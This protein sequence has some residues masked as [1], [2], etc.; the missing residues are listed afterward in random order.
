MNEDDLKAPYRKL[1]AVEDQIELN[2][3]LE[4]YTGYFKQK[5]KGMPIFPVD[6]IQ[7]KWAKD[8]KKLCGMKAAE[9]IEHYFSMKDEWFIKQA[10][11]LECLVKN[12]NKVN[13]SFSQNSHLRQSHNQITIAVFCDACWKEFPLTVS[14]NHDFN[15]PHKCPDCVIK[16]RPLKRVEREKRLKIVKALGAAFKDL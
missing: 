9:I 5:F 4:V 10:Y 15:H 14:I 6:N 7:F 11:S 13:A 8:L 2:W 16:N 1:Q 12:I 3:I